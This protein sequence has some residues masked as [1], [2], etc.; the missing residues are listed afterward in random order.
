MSRVE[1]VR[2]KTTL[3]IE[4]GIHP[5]PL[6]QCLIALSDGKISF[7]SFIRKGDENYAIEEMKQDLDGSLFL[8]SPEKTR[9][10]KNR[11][12]PSRKNIDPSPIELTVMGTPFQIKVWKELLRIPYGSQTS[13]QEIAKRVGFPRAARAVGNAIGQNR[14]SYLIPCHRVIRKS[15]DPGKYRWGEDQK[16]KLLFLESRSIKS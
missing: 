3:N 9:L 13:Y 5:T 14:I 7:F 15:G 11:I 2:K 8:E 4:Y 10:F 6:G 1:F 16:K 12:F